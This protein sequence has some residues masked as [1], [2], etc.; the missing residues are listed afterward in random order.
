MKRNLTLPK[1]LKKIRSAVLSDGT[2]SDTQVDA[3]LSNP[4]A[5]ASHY[6]RIV[7]RKK[8]GKKRTLHIPSNILKAIHY[9]IKNEL[10]KYYVSEDFV[11]GF[12]KGKNST[13]NAFP[14]VKSP[15]ILVLDIQD[16]FNSIRESFLRIQ[17]EKFTGNLRLAKWITKIVVTTKKFL[18]QGSPLSPLLSNIVFKP[19]D[20]EIYEFCEN[21]QVTYTRYADDLTFSFNKNLTSEERKNFVKQIQQILRKYGFHTNP[22]KT[23]FRSAHQPQRVTG[24]IVNEKLNVPRKERKLLRHYLYLWET[25][26]YAKAEALFQ[27]QHPKKNLVTFLE[28]KMAYFT[29]ILGEYHD[30]LTKMKIKFKSLKSILQT[31]ENN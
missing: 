13:H 12:V 7:I 20:K 9:A 19:V 31:S 8:K 14:H 22:N 6:K 18:P 23:R 25:Y 28:G 30:A 29:M 10:E 17:L 1:F 5:A 16:F 15:L 21:Q 4:S 2:F 3:L 11:N 24:I 27:N 26:G